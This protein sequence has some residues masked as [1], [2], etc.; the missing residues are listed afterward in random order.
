[1]T[2]FRV[3]Q[4][5]RVVDDCSTL[6]GMAGEVWDTDSNGRVAAEVA[7]AVYWL[8]PDILFVVPEPGIPGHLRPVPLSPQTR[9][10]GGWA[11]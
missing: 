10:L 8:P 6:H 4:R 3:G 1:M 11:S 7:G 9:H 2:Q 5:V